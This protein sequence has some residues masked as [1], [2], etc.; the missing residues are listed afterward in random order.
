[1]KNKTIGILLCV[2]SLILVIS[3]LLYKSEIDKKN[4]H[5]CN[6]GCSEKSSICTQTDQCPFVQ[7]TP[8]TLIIS[9]IL[10]IVLFGFGINIA[11]SKKSEPDSKEKEF[12]ILKKALS[13]DEKLVLEEIKKAGEITQDSL[14]F[15]LNWSKAKLSAILSNLD[16]LNLIQRE[17]QG[18]TYKVFIK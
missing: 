9:L 8:L 5:F 15:R 16:R 7:G 17:R 14:K 18:K 6:I 3:L 2:I 4:Q 13:N 11:L 1:M 12:S 10:L